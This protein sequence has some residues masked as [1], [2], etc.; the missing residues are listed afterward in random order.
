MTKNIL[1]SLEL[2]SGMA[3]IP[4]GF[5]SA[6]EYAVFAENHDV[7]GIIV[8]EESFNDQEHER[9]IDIITDIAR[10]SSIKLYGYSRIKRMEDAKKLFYA[11][12]SYVIFPYYD[13]KD[14]D[15]LKETS[16]KFGSDRM[17]VSYREGA[18]P[19]TA[20][21]RDDFLQYA[22]MIYRNKIKYPVG[23]EGEFTKGKISVEEMPKILVAPN[24]DK[25]SVY[26][27]LKKEDLCG[28]NCRFFADNI[29][30]IC[31]FKADAVNKGYEMNFP[32]PKLSFADL[33]KDAQGL[34][35]VIA[36]DYQTGEVL[37]MAYM[38][39]EAFVRTIE[40]GKMNY[41]SRSR[42]EQWLKGETSGHYQFVKELIA[43][44]DQDTILAKVHQA[45]AACHTGSYSCFFNEILKKE[46]DEKNPMKVLEDVFAVIMD[47]KVNP[48]E[49]SY[50]NYLF[51]KGIDKILKKVGEEAT[52]IV[53]AAKNPNANEIKYEIADFLYHMMVLMA[54]K[55]IDWKDIA[56]ELARRE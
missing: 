16:L 54:E 28:I 46:Y 30:D 10:N 49:G 37:M 21:N 3:F 55:G 12:C 33:K 38:N 14:L 22:S 40:T 2:R 31:A 53:I 34:V 8:Y 17:I 50:T 56:D 41:Y 29:S 52:E 23:C 1:L 13:E 44:C 18:C 24:N 35:P 27:F 48:R 42:N 5:E 6:T 11:G 36:T 20:E 26:D 7:D 15:V 9:N 32:L 43:D 47:R 51:N 4:E 19:N 39:E 45:G 25:D